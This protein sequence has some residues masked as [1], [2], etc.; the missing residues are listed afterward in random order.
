MKP[1]RWTTHATKNLVDREIDR[2]EVE[3]ALQAPEYVVD[4][5]PDRQIFMRRYIDKILQQEMLLR[6]VVEESGD[7]TVV[8]TVYKTSRMDRYLKGLGS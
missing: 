7:E 3:Y 5:A 8:I 4:D 1:V 2:Q 6:V